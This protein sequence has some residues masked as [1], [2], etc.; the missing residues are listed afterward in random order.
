VDRP[1]LSVAIASGQGWPYVRDLIA[2]I[3]P[4]AEA[5]GAEIVVADGSRNAAPTDA[6]VGSAVRWIKAQ[7]ESVFQLFSTALRASRGDVVAL[8]EDHAIPRQGWIP[9]VM[10]AH[11]EHPEAAAIGGAIENGSTFGLIEWA[12]YFTTQG[13]HMSPLG[14]RVVPT[15]TNEAN[16]SY[17]G[18]VIAEVDPD[19]G[20]G[21]MAILYNRRLSEQGRILRVDDRIVVD[22]FE[23]IGFGWTTSIHFHNGRTISGF[24][25]E[26]GMTREDYVRVATSLMLPAWRTLRA[27]RVGWAKGRLRR[28]LIVSA[29]F[30]LW[31]EYV[32]ALG[33]LTGYVAGP[34]DSPRHLR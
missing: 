11:E 24:R 28:E 33:H 6:E 31:L 17:K 21:F 16:V 34:G 8:T 12:S 13:P 9:A 10:R 14:N 2:A 4:D 7:G 29:P 19:E 15:T 20:L 18:S 26:R 1:V 23:T 5:A 27:F 22:H 30:A 3:R 32:Q 25:R